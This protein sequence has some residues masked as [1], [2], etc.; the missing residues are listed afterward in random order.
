MTADIL[1]FGTY[2]TTRLLGNFTQQAD[3]VSQGMNVFKQE[4]DEVG[5]SLMEITCSLLIAHNIIN[6]M[7]IG[8]RHRQSFHK[9]CIET[10]DGGDID[11]MTA[12]AEAIKSHKPPS[13]IPPQS[14]RKS[15]NIVHVKT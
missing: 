14:H 1:N 7:S 3:G 4:I 5:D 10:I 6:N 11:K 8:L 9:L 2:R 12:M 13:A 15:G